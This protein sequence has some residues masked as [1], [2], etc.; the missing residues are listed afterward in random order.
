MMWNQT[1]LHHN[2]RAGGN[3]LVGTT[4]FWVDQAYLAGNL[5][6]RPGIGAERRETIVKF[7]SFG[8]IA[9]GI[10]DSRANFASGGADRR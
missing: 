1:S 6:P 2:L 5:W 9:A 3:F 10:G 8:S 4:V 7:T